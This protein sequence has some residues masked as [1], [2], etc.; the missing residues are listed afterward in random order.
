MLELT[1]YD[2]GKAVK[3][4][5]EHSLLSVSK[6][7]ALYKK[8]FHTPEPKPYDEMLEYCKF[9]LL[10]RKKSPELVYALEPEQFERL[11][12]YI[13]DTPSASSV[14][15]DPNQA[16]SREVLTSELIYYW[17]TELNIPFQP[18]ETWHLQRLMMLIQ[19]ASH[20][21]QP[22]KKQN[23]NKVSRDWAAENERR[24]KL[25]MTKG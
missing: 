19:I 13:A 20:K 9:M 8:P 5:F 21:K 14:P 10:N 16:P 1:V 3:L 17:M 7:E 23:P 25:F 4:A 18:T 12:D 11:L 15:T 6:W 22:P 24:K 2:Q